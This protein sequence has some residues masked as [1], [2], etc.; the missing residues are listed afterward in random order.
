MHRWQNIFFI[1]QSVGD[2]IAVGCNVKAAE[3]LLQL[4]V[5]SDTK[6]L[7]NARRAVIRS[8]KQPEDPWRKFL[9]QRT[10]QAAAE[11]AGMLMVP[12]ANSLTPPR[13][14]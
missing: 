1:Y 9:A 8:M 4:S 11:E 5:H 6:A 12:S 10:F 7:C 13:T 2:K 14:V 3:V